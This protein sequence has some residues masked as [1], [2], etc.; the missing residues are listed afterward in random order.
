MNTFGHVIKFERIRQNIKQV[1]LSDGICTP[2]YLSKIESNSIVPS[3][4]ILELLFERL[5]LKFNN[6]DMTE[7][8]YLLMFRDFYFEALKTKDI[9]K[10]AL[11]LEKFTQEGYLFSN[12]SFYYSYLLMYFRLKVLT[13]NIE[14]DTLNFISTI[15]KSS[16]DFDSYQLFQLNT[17]IGYYHFYKFEYDPT[18]QAFEKAQDYL[19]NCTVD[20]CEVADFNYLIGL[21]CFHQEKLVASKEY[22][23]NALEYYTKEF[24]YTRAT[25]CYITNALIQRRSMKF[26]EGR[27]TLLL[28][29]KLAK[30][31]KA[32][33]Y[34]LSLI[35][36]NLA[37]IYA[38]N[39]DHLKA[40]QAYMNSMNLSEDPAVKIRY[41]YSIVL[42]TSKMNN[43]DE[44]IKWSDLGIKIYETH[45]SDEIEPYYFHLKYYQSAYTN[46][47][48]LTIILETL[49]KHFAK[50][51]DYRHAYKYSIK[52]ASLLHRE[53]KYQKAAK[54]YSKANSYLSLREKRKFKEEI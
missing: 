39:K 1:Q 8:E 25:E 26:I 18:F 5:S 32:E 47:D 34:L 36:F 33:D 7:E 16:D 2:S 20:D 3:E 4:E 49:I 12:P 31:S 52:L 44:V 29:E 11:V 54:Y 15:A 22:M 37:S 13:F 50:H 51:N 45:P 28:A 48:N 43:R 14:E 46:A 10:T 53:K 30:L 6:N 24:L 21:I 38:L 17:C 41:I 42:E 35:Y 40:T 19:K 9:E 27:E 23:N